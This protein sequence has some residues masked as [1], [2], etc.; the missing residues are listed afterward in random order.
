MLNKIFLFPGQGSQ[1]VNMFDNVEDSLLAEFESFFGYRKITEELLSRTLHCQPMI[2]LASYDGFL[3]SDKTADGF[4]GHSLGE[5]GAFLAAGVL[6]LEDGF[7]VI[8]ARAEAMDRYARGGMSAVLKLEANVIEEVVLNMTGV[9][10]ANYNSPLQ[11]VIAGENDALEKAANALKEKGARV[12]P[13]K[14]AGAFH[15]P[16]MQPAAEEFFDKI[17]HI[18]FN[19]PNKTIYSNLTGT[20]ITKV[21]KENLAKHITNPVRFTDELLQM[22]KDGFGEFIEMPPGNVLTGLVN[23][24]LNI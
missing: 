17:Q 22:Q 6:S 1:T 13:L 21:E 3:K 14:T 4:A 9:W 19:A 5:Y 15:T 18:V 11:T 8:K 23:K 10:V 12:M 7:K 24:T 2:M 20:A 16:I